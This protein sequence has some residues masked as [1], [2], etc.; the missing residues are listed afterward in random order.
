MTTTTTTTTTTITDLICPNKGVDNIV[1]IKDWAKSTSMD[2]L[3]EEAG[4]PAKVFFSF[5]SLFFFSPRREW[6][7]VKVFFTEFYI[8]AFGCMYGANT[9][10]QI[11]TFPTA[12]RHL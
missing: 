1:P 11:H 8:R 3:Q 4:R 12:D 10:M 6:R 7:F 2:T 5:F 9:L